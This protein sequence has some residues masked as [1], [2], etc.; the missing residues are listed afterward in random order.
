MNIKDLV[1]L[2]G[3]I[4]ES[5]NISEETIIASLQ[6]GIKIAYR[7]HISCPDATVRIDVSG[8]TLKVYQQ[9]KV[10][11]EGDVVDDDIEMSIEDAR[12]IKPDAKLDDIMEEEVNI[13][14]FGRSAVHQIKQTLNQKIV[15][16]NKQVIYNEYVDKIDDLVTGT[17]ETVEDKFALV[18][19]GK[20]IAIMPKSEQIPNENYY[21]GQRIRV[22]IKEVNDPNSKVKDKKEKKGA[23]VVVSRASASLIKRLFEVSVPE[24][25]DGT[26]T[27]NAISREAG[28]RT[29]MAVS[30]RN[31]NVDAIGACIGP[32]GQRVV[33][34]LEE[35]TGKNGVSHEN[36]DIVEYSNDY[37]E[38][39]K[40]ILK[41]AEVLGIME[42]PSEDDRRKGLIVIVDNEKLSS[43]IGKKGIN[44]KLTGKM[45]G[46]NVDIKSR[47]TAE[48]EGINWEEEMVKFTAKIQMKQRLEAAERLAAQQAELERKQAEEAALKAQQAVEEVVE[49]VEEP[50]KETV[51]EIKEEVKETVEKVE[52][53]TDEE[54]K[55]VVKH[56]K[57][58]L[59]VKAGDYVSKFEE[60]A[61]AKKTESNKG[62]GKKKKNTKEEDETLQLKEKLDELKN[63]DYEFKPE[64]SDEELEEFENAD[65]N[66]WYDSDEEL[67]FDEYDSYY[68]EQ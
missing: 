65:D 60:L 59:T 32:R 12:E 37:I 44:A 36:I 26:V 35:V 18:N 68:D 19:I 49:E 41:P 42:A 39:I 46:C 29:K 61:D 8:D 34:V 52:E 27:I 62:T 7:K 10:V 21:D 48:E 30:S 11:E 1:G 17:I 31:P 38:F 53:K 3:D 28:E 25:Y 57:P 56:R 45:L 24:I 22:I 66:N 20:T 40:N 50:I 64:Y 58:K 43:A 15:E 14:E 51:E 16:A 47:T 5:R 23:Q 2:I 54:I 4:G 55:E 67:D 63:K 9:R 33:A 6:E 13:A